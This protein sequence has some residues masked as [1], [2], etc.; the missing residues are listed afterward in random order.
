[1]YHSFER[2]V[3][4]SMGPFQNMYGENI[5]TD[6]ILD[7]INMSLAEYDSLPEYIPGLDGDDR[8]Y[9][10]IPGYDDGEYIDTDDSYP[11][12]MQGEEDFA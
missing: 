5:T 9:D 12:D 6:D 4:D 3:T 2:I 10:Y 11:E 8:T 7:D 1:M